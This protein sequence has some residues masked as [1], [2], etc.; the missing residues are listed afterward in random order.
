MSSPLSLVLAPGMALMR[1]LRL[2]A[3]ITLTGMMLFVPLLVLLALALSA[4]R[5]ELAY[6][7]QETE[8][9]RLVGALLDVATPLQAH[10]GLTNR[11]LSGDTAAT[12]A[13]DAT[14]QALRAA[15]GAVDERVRV[16]TAFRIDDA[17]PPTRD[18]IVALAEGRHD[19][20]RTRA[21]A[22]HSE[23]VEALRQL[24]QLVAERSGL[25]FD[26]EPASYYLMSIAVD[27]L[28]PWTEALGMLRGQG[29]ALLAR[30]DASAHERAQML[31]RAEALQRQLGEL[32][33]RIT[34]LQRAGVAPPAAFADAAAAARAYAQRVQ[35]V[36]AGDAALTD[37]PA[38]FF[39]QGSAAIAQAVAVKGQVLQAL[40]D[41][42][43][44]R[45]DA[46]QW[47]A[48]LQTA[49]T[50]AGLALLG[51]FGLCFYLSFTG[52]LKALT[53]GVQ[54]VADGNL[55][56][57][58]AIRGRDELA[59]IG[60]IVERMADR[61]SAMVAEIRSSAVRVSG[62]GEQ[63]AHDS[64]ALAQRTEE[65]AASLRQFVTTVEELSAAVA[66]NAEQAQQLDQITGD[67]HQRAEAGGAAMRDT[68]DS[69]GALEAGSKRVG[70][71][72][73]VIDGIAFQTNILALNAAVEAARAGD[74]GRGFAVV[75]SEV[76]ALAQRSANAAAEIR[77]L[78]A[79]SGEQVGAT[80][81]RVQ[82]MS[83][84]LQQMVDGVRD[85]SVRLRQIAQASAEQ[86]RGLEE[87]A[88]SVGNLDEIT[89]RNAALVEESTSSSQE[90]VERAAKLA[91]AV[92]S[93][94]LRQGSA[95]EARALVERA[96]ALIHARGRAAAAPV[97][98]STDEGFVDRDLYVFLLDRQGRYVLHGAKPTMEGK[99]VHEVP[100]I[101][102]ERFV[103][104]AWAAAD[105]GGGW[106][107]YDIVNPATGQVQPKAS[108]V[109]PLDRD[110]LVG[111]GVYRHVETATA[112]RAPLAEPPAVTRTAPRLAAA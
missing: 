82:G 92:S 97:L 35:A 102:G 25:L 33:A 43:A 52:A 85:V 79:Q 36:F 62:T 67:L 44:Q 70:E 17:W 12:V 56:H 71:I 89:R 16:L 39:D 84:S 54:A 23:Q 76:R 11:V 4:V 80:V 109:R 9:A 110:V 53:R 95:D 42:F 63:L 41:A 31:A 83:G 105:A 3:K 68:V 57:R 91:Q 86:S 78:I 37:E 45:I 38:P 6:T 59:D 73:G 27:Q 10:R 26:P 106:V 72:I 112:A 77:T 48:A 40:D 96:L 50:L 13:R 65:Q 7:H 58:F 24:L 90:L 46:L 8:G 94:R 99:R 30:G 49:A 98:H 88:R 108:F 29:A 107:E 47:R 87:M 93:M 28:L 103:R 69:L 18:A 64:A 20:Q 60:A 32:E 66:S 81:E 22:Q 14:R 51:Y 55:A 100:G 19:A 74:A 2:P 1:R 111:C 61:L 21:F 104:D 101:D 15:L 5:G 75:A 34:A